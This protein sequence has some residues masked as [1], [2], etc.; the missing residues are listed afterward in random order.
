MESVTYFIQWSKLDRE[1]VCTKFIWLHCADVKYFPCY[2]VVDAAR[3]K[4]MKLKLLDGTL[5]R[6]SSGAFHMPIFAFQNYN[7]CSVHRNI[8]SNE[9]NCTACNNVYYP[10]YARCNI[11]RRMRGVGF[12]SKNKREHD[13]RGQH[14]SYTVPMFRRTYSRLRKISP[15]IPHYNRRCP[16]K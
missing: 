8:F 2:V 1:L 6:K 14:V 15:D 9:A 3:F 5:F 4:I 12:M 13:V 10:S 7:F 11:W 16:I